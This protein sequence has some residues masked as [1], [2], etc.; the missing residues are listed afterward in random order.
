MHGA[1]FRYQ[2]CPRHAFSGYSATVYLRNGKVYMPTQGPCTGMF[3]TDACATVVA[4]EMGAKWE[5]VIIEYDKKA[6]FTPVGGGSDGT[7][8]AAWVVKEAAGLCRK[9]VFE[10]AAE[11]LKARPEDLDASDSVVF[12]KSDPSKKLP[13]SS[14]GNIGATF[15]GRPPAAIWGQMGKALDIINTLYCEVAVDTE[16][17]EVEVLRWGVAIDPGKVLRRISL[18]GQIHQ[19]MMFSDGIGRSEEFIFDKQSGVRLTANM[20]DYKKP[21]ITDIAPTQ[22]GIIES[23]GGNAAYGCGGISHSMAN[24]HM[25]VCA[26]HNAIGKWVDPPA[27]PAKI[28]NALGKA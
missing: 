27:T 4:E 11:Q 12:V 7:S 14:L 21:T 2:M 20:F 28:L 19:V 3:A 13:F 9:K 10:A 6:P 22:F 17:G 25:I 15:D 24:T 1:A 8:S 18:E 16:T 23:R 5:D 26:I